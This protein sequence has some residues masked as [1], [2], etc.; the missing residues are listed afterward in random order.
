MGWVSKRVKTDLA[1]VKGR[2]QRHLQPGRLGWA[3][4]MEK[5]ARSLRTR[6]D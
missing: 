5:K 6:L 3:P 2:W 4:A 1:F